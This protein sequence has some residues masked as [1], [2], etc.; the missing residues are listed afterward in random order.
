VNSVTTLPCETWNAHCALA[1]IELLQKETPPH[2]CP[3][4]LPD[5]NPVDNTMSEILQEI[6]N[7][8][9]ITDLAPSAMPLTNCCRIDDMIQL[10]HSVLKSLF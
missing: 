7:E 1:T 9:R 2:L 3:P 4:N 8:I 10:G 6:V 5:L